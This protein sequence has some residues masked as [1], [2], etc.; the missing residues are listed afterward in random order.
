M[1]RYWV[2]GLLSIIIALNGMAFTR[3][4]S[5]APNAD[6]APASDTNPPPGPD[7]FTVLTVEYQAYEWQM[8]TWK[9]QKPV[10]TLIIDHEGMPLPGEVY[11]DC[12]ETSTKIGSYKT[13]ACQKTKEPAQVTI[14]SKATVTWKRRK[15]RWNSSLPAAWISLEDCEPVASASTNICEGKPTLVITGQEPLQDKSIIRIEGT[16]NGEPFDCEGRYLQ[17]PN[18]RNRSRKACP[19]NSGPTPL[20]ATAA[21]F[22]LPRSAYKKRMK[23][24]PI[25]FTG[26]SMSC[27]HNGRD[28]A[29]PP[30]PIHG[31]FSRPLAVLPNGSPPPNKAKNL[32]ATFPTPISLRT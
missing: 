20:T 5:S 15:S 14:S 23:A 17:I 28:K 12:G 27:L 26:M 10:C 7:R 2:L 16:Y 31:T 29:S 30:A 22:S 19:L 13:P 32:A 21:S 3:Q 18:C 24:T 8:A 6:T 1:R 4:N 9:Y 11:R 25:N